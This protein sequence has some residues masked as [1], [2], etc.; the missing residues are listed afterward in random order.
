M[1][2]LHLK[3]IDSTNSYVKNNIKD[4][5][6]LTFVYSDRQ[7]KGR[8]RLNRKW[9]D[10]G[11]ENLFLTIVIKPND[12]S[13]KNMPNMTQ[14][15]SV[16][17]SMVLEE[18]YNLEPQIKW[19]N[20]ILVNNKKIAGILAEGTTCGNNFLGLALGVG[21]NLNTPKEKLEL[22]DK[23]ATSIFN[24]TG[25]HIQRD[26]FLE[27][28]YNKFCLLYDRFVCDGF[29]YIKD[30]YET[31]STILGNKISINV[32]GNI[33]KGIAKRLTDDGALVLGENNKEN[34]YYIGDIL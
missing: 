1:K 27:K 14:Y 33:H 21:V 13:L 7:N 11:N 9:H 16:I 8:G 3:E 10:F 4:L 12:N 15:L 24:E 31:K 30:Y 20:D 26:D 29:V 5:N 25:Y 28:L 18:Y 6:H 22:I 19:P 23:P 17:L 32:L 34:T 2:L